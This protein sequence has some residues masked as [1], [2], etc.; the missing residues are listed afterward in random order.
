MRREKHTA[1]AHTTNKRNDECR[2]QIMFKNI[3]AVAYPGL[4]RG[5]RPRAVSGDEPPPALLSL[6]VGKGS[7]R[8]GP[9]NLPHTNRR[10]VTRERSDREAPS[11]A[12][13][14]WKSTYQHQGQLGAGVCSPATLPAQPWPAGS[15]RSSAGLGGAGVRRTRASQQE[16]LPLCTEPPGSGLSL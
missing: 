14:L 13:L 10:F 6:F 16:G 9:F 4:C 2:R 12:Q 3:D 5:L 15:L 1:V 11:R 7:A 8:Q